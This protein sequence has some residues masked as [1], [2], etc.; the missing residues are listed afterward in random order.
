MLMEYER[1]RGAL[2][3]GGALIGRR[4]LNRIITVD[5]FQHIVHPYYWQSII[6]ALSLNI[7][8]FKVLSL[9]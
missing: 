4:A 3:R 6:F 5:I 2:I 8:V 7:V 1:I 9:Y